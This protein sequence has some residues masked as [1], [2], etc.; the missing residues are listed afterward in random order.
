MSV[1]SESVL[2]SLFVQYGILLEVSLQLRLGYF[3]G[4]KAGYSTRTCKSKLN[5][6]SALRPHM[7]SEE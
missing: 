2:E 4:D 1:R 5:I 7:N 6:N 3:V